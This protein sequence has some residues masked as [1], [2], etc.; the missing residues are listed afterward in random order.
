ME[1]KNNKKKIPKFINTENSLVDA[2]GGVGCWVKRVKEVK[3]HKLPVIS[4]RDVMF[5]LMTIVGDKAWCI[6]KLLGSYISEVITGKKVYVAI[7]P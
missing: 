1:S 7:S 2:R 5:S 4:H 6:G 3:R